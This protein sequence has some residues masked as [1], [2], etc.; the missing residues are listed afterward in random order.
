MSSRL[1][2]GRTIAALFFFGV[3]CLNFRVCLLQYAESRRRQRFQCPVALSVDF[4][5]PN[6]YSA[7]FDRGN[8]YVRDAYLG[9]DIPETALSGAAPEAL[10]ASLQ[11]TYAVL[12]AEGKKGPAPLHR[13]STRIGCLVSR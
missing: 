8:A 10:L 12:D 5:A 1:P 9:L 2:I 7:S 3:A 6:A 4:S 13:M 11:G